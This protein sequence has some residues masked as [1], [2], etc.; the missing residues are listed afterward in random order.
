MNI[1]FFF[2]SRYL[3]S[4]K[5]YSIGT[6]I[7]LLSSISIC[8][9]VIILLLT[10]SISNGFLLKVENNIF[11]FDP[12][13]VIFSNQIGENIKSI[14]EKNIFKNKYIKSINFTFYSQ[15]FLKSSSGFFN[16]LL[17]VGSYSNKNNSKNKII[18]KNKNNNLESIVIGNILSKKMNVVVGEIIFITPLFLNN[19]TILFLP[20]KIIGLLNTGI[21]NYDE[22]LI[23][24]NSENCYKLFNSKYEAKYA[25]IILKDISKIENASQKIKEKLGYNFIVKRKAG[26][27]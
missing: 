3:I 6:F 27:S 25:E 13:I 14:K 8:I 17:K 19:Y 21:Q 22:F 24:I 15:V 26:Y 18:T 9:S 16:A 5:K 20:F 7:N 4:N 11:K 10:I 2:F 23:C 12:H 1:E